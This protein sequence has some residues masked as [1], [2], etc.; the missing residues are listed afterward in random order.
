MSEYNKMEQRQ[1]ARAELLSD[2][3]KGEICQKEHGDA[4]VNHARGDCIVSCTETGA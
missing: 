3:D 4:F 2:V 1:T